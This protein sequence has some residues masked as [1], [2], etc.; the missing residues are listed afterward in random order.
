[1]AY[2]RDKY[3]RAKADGKPAMTHS[4]AFFEPDHDGI[5]EQSPSSSKDGKA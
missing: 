4:P 2:N 1:M 3:L 5:F